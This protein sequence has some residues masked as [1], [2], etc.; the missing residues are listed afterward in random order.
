MQIKLGILDQ[1][2]VREYCSHQQALQESAKLVQ[3]ADE[4]GFHRYWIAEHHTFS[5]FVSSTPEVLIPFFA[6]STRKI[7]IGAGGMLAPNHSTYRLAEIFTLLADLFPSR[8]DLGIG[9]S[10]GGDD[11][12]VHRTRVHQGEQS[13]H[14]RPMEGPG[15][16]PRIATMST[17]SA[18]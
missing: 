8:I 4:A 2:A 10:S 17:R 5:Q 7:R 3:H 11:D 18:P 12:R 13:R 14:A 6:S 16:C 9:R 1:I 15:R